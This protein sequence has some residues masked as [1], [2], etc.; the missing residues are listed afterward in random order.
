MNREFSED[1]AAIHLW[2]VQ[3][4][5]QPLQKHSMGIYSESLSYVSKN[6]PIDHS[7]SCSQS[8]RELHTKPEI[9]SR[10]SNR[11]VSGEYGERNK[12]KP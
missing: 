11:H 10:E 3:N 8:T 4:F 2:A 5:Q 1:G 7:L 9:L 6:R 12:N